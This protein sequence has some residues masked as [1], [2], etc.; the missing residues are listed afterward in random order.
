MIRHSSLSPIVADPA[1]LPPE[2]TPDGSWRLFAH[3]AW[4]IHEYVSPDGQSWRDRGLVIRDAM[5]PWVLRDDGRWYLL[6]EGY[7]PLGLALSWV[8]GRAF[9]WMIVLLV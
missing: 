6:Y 7:R 1:V 2:S 8:P 5:R 3:S 4:G 9:F